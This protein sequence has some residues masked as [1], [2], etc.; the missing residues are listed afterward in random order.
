MLSGGLN[1]IQ[2]AL[3]GQKNLH[4]CK[5]RPGS[6]LSLANLSEP[7]DIYYLVRELLK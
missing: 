5:L 6:Q 4:P 2:A 1:I 7:V 3:S